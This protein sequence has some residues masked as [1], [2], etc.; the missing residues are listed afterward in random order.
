L[1]PYQQQRELMRQHLTPEQVDFLLMRTPKKE[2]KTR[3]GPGGKVF[4]YVDHGYVTERL[5]VV[6]GFQW[7]F[8]VVEWR[9]L[10]EEVIV[11]G[12]LTVELPNGKTIVKQQFGGADIKRFA[13]GKKQG[14]PISVA[15][16]LKAAASDALK[17]CASLLGIGLDLYRGEGSIQRQETARDPGSM[18]NRD[19]GR[20]NKEALR[21][22]IGNVAKRRRMTD[23]E[24]LERLSELTGGRNWGDL[25]LNEAADVAAAF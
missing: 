3:E 13:G 16:D 5:N 10:D 15:D 9:T 19:E 25:S 1:T 21:Q 12:K 23:V 14:M 6:F 4:S 8:E 17:K 2:I 20:P 7:S 18:G 22:Q 11:E 24:I